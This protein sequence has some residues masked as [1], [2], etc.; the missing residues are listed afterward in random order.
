M[1]GKKPLPDGVGK[2]PLS[3]IIAQQIMMKN[4][5]QQDAQQ[6]QYEQ[7]KSADESQ[8]EEDG[9]KNPFLEDESS[10]LDDPK[11]PFTKSYE[12]FIIHNLVKE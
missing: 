6:Q 9:Q 3:P 7:G 12:E 2:Y 8:K 10:P 1:Q 4:Q 5:N 11:N